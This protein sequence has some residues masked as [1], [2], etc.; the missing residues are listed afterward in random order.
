M[1]CRTLPAIGRGKIPFSSFFTHLHTHTHTRTHTHT[2]THRSA[3]THTQARTHTQ[4]SVSWREGRPEREPSTHRSSKKHT[5]TDNA[6]RPHAQRRAPLLH[7][8]TQAQARGQTQQNSRKGSALARQPVQRYQ[9]RSE[10]SGPVV[11]L[12][13]VAQSQVQ[14]LFFDVGY[15]RVVVHVGSP[16]TA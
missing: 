15:V 12:P 10:L 3:Q 13:G 5:H 16:A 9:H 1:F 2:H 6:Q 4:C 8:Q 11:L 14:Q 7:K